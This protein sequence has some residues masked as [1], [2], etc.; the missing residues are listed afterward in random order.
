MS[1][2]M[3]FV[4]EFWRDE[5]DV[6]I[7]ETLAQKLLYALADKCT[8]S[9]LGDNSLD[10]TVII[11]FQEGKKFLGILRKLNPEKEAL[12]LFRGTSLVHGANQTEVRM[13][14]ENLKAIAASPGELLLDER[15]CL[16]LAI[17]DA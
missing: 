7:G 16:L 17:D 1:R 14:F 2:Q 8:P 12:K 15:G 4:Q 6:S 13:F 3:R 9:N 10:G 11:R 5:A